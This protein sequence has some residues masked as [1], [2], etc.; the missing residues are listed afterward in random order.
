[1]IALLASVGMETDA[2]ARSIVFQENIRQNFVSAFKSI[3]E[4]N[5]R[6]DL[7]AQ[8]FQTPSGD[9]AILLVISKIDTSTDT[10]VFSFFGDGPADQLNV[11]NNLHSATFSGT[12][13]AFEDSTGEEMTFT[14]DVD[15]TATGNPEALNSSER[16]I[17]QDFKFIE[18]INAKT[19]PA[20]GSMDISGDGMT[21]S[22]DD[23]SGDIAKVKTGQ[24]E[25]EKL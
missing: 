20:S 17:T 13:T 21:F 9:I 14:V 18:N 16:I 7:F 5:I 2:A 22:I 19:R 1:V 8:G 25:V 4:G 3:E 24:I 11:A 10:F 23:A 12:V 6:T 15:L